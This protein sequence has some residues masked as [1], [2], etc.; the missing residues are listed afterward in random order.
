MA[1][2]KIV[3][4]GGTGFVGQGIISALSPEKYDIHVLTRRNVTTDTESVTYHQV[5]YHV[6]EQ[7]LAVIGDADWVI[8]VIGILLPNPIK[9]QTYANSSVLPAKILIDAVRACPEVHV[10]VGQLRTFLHGTIH[11]CEARSGELHGF[12]FATAGNDAVSRYYL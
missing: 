1:K 3:I 4:A 2:K 6:T 5:D 9:H 8:D 7:V 11:A 12:A 10:R